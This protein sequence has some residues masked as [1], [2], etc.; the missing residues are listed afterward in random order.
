ME[1]LQVLQENVQYSL[2][3]KIKFNKSRYTMSG[4]QI[5]LLYEK[6]NGYK[7]F[8]L[9][10]GVFIDRLGKFSEDYNV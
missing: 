8:E 5:G 7:N 1:L 3:L 9:I 6:D 4:I 2:L 10:H